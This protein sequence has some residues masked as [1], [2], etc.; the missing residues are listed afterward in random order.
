MRQYDRICH[1]IVTRYVKGFDKITV[2][3]FLNNRGSQIQFQKIKIEIDFCS[4]SSAD[5]SK[6]II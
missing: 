2:R 4:L 3:N 5:P 6:F 1:F